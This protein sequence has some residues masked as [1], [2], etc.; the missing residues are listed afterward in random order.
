MSRLDKESQW[1]LFLAQVGLIKN[2]L[3]KKLPFLC[4]VCQYD[5]H[6]NIV[7]DIKQILRNKIQV[8]FKFS[9]YLTCF[10]LSPF[11]YRHK[12][13]W[14]LDYIYMSEQMDQDLA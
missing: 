3:L 9:T 1:V 4:L 6:D 10:H 8:S 14:H 5:Y 11:F 2:A 12:F 13:K 7:L